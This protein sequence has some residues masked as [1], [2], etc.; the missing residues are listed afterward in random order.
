MS[1]SGCWQQLRAT[2][3]QL[4]TEKPMELQLGYP[5]YIIPLIGVNRDGVRAGQYINDIGAPLFGR[6]VQLFFDVAKD[7]GLPNKNDIV[8]AH[9]WWFTIFGLATLMVIQG[10]VPD[11]PDQALVAE[12]TIATLWAGVQAV[13]RSPKSAIPKR[14]GRSRPSK[15]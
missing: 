12:Q 9:T 10:V 4:A 15:Q 6:F 3:V 7:E 5:L 11:L 8:V 13:P 1:A 14:P 2:R